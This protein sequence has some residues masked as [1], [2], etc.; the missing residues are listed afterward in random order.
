[1][2]LHREIIIQNNNDSSQGISFFFF[3]FLQMIYFYLVK[4]PWHGV[5]SWNLFCA[6]FVRNLVRKLILL[7]Y[8]C[9]WRL[10]FIWLLL[11]VSGSRFL[12]LETLVSIFGFLFCTLELVSR[13]M[14]FWW[15]ELRRNLQAGSI[16]WCLRW[17]DYCWSTLVWPCHQHMSCNLL[18]CHAIY[19]DPTTQEKVHKEFF[20]RV[21]ERKRTLRTITWNRV[22]PPKELGGLAIPNLKHL[23]IAYM[24]KLRWRLAKQS[25]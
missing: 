21:S 23:N 12:K 3:F 11:I 20:G 25:G 14:I 22:C 7:S 5:E 6:P 10:I 2:H 15:I 24:V 18:W 9:R 4:R 1:M 16:I 17:L 8:L 13:L 19:Y